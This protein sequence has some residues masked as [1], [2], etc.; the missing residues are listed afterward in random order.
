MQTFFEWFMEDKRN[1]EQPW[2]IFGKGPSFSRRKDFDLS[3]FNTLSL[4]HA[5]REQS[6]RVAHMIDFD[7]AENCA[8]VLSMKAEFVVMPWIPHVNN[9][10]GRDTLADLVGVHEFLHALS[11]Q[12]RLLWYNLSTSEQANLD[13]PTVSVK[14]FSAEAAINLLSMAGVRNIKSL[15]IDGG[16]SYSEEFSDLNGKTLLANGRSSFNRQF[17]QIARTIMKTGVSYSPLN[18]ESPIRVFVA[19]TKSEA[20]PAKILE[21]SIRRHTS[22]SVEVAP[23]YASE[24]DI[25]LPKEVKNHPRTPFSFQRFVIPQLCG[26]KGRAIY[27][28]SDMLVFSDL[29]ELW[30]HPMNGADIL[31]VRSGT[32]VG[33]K[34]QFSVMMINNESLRWDISE[35]VRALDEGRLSYE[36][37]MYAMKIAPDIQDTISP[38][39]NSLEHYRESETALLHYTDMGTQPWVSTA[40]PLGY[41]WMRNLLDA[42]DEGFVSV[43]QIEEEIKLGHVRPS[44][45]YQIDHRLDD[46]L[47]LPAKARK[48]DKDFR[49]PYCT[50]QTRGG[51]SLRTLLVM[52][53]AA[54]RNFYEGTPIYRVRRKI[55]NRTKDR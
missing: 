41:L 44:L 54:M 17:E 21:F 31:T 23:L 30:T 38:R 16:G 2:L 51:R 25:P 52:V 20:L 34:P 19:A 50:I 1:S 15:G 55:A 32:D 39:W 49:A 46:P 35:I 43:S 4:N 33:R 22:M 18:I 5:V 8:D 12:G 6:V 36:D 24:I 11:K 37:L 53:R 27:F 45:L 40:N 10:P 28:D 42:I 48:M 26:Y 7:V 13:S 3:E 9:R 29:R 14:F 47:L